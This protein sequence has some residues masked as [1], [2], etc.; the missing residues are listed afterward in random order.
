[1]F[2]NLTDHIKSITKRADTHH[3]KIEKELDK[4]HDKKSKRIEELM[5]LQS[6]LPHLKQIHQ[7]LTK[8][9]GY[10]ENNISKEDVIK[11]KNDINEAV[12]RY[13][14]LEQSMNEIE[15]SIKALEFALIDEVNAEST[16]V[17]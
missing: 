12:K 11:A 5:S 8:S 4:L 10:S 14:E 9:F 17:S 1:M 3:S 7:A 6:T 13:K 15:A 2:K 16:I